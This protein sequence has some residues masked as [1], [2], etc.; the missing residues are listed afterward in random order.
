[1]SCDLRILMDQP[2]ESIPSHNPSSRRD[3]RGIRVLRTPVRAP[4]P[5]AYAE[6]W[7]GTVRRELLDRMLIV[8]CRQ[9]RWA[10][11]EYADHYNGHRP[12]RALG[13]APPLGYGEPPI[14]P[15]AGRVVRRDRLGGLIHEYARRCCIAP[16][17]GKFSAISTWGS[18]R[19]RQV[20]ERDGQPPARHL[21]SSQLVMAPSNILDEGMAAN[22]HTGGTVLLEAAHRP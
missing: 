12:H 4:R 13:Q 17:Q 2:A 1:M 3:D 7:V 5:N 9:L 14:I 18:D 11:T 21:L 6:R 10:L 8:G 16:G 22:D 20:V 15:A 19:H